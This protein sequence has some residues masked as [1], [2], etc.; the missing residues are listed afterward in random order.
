MGVASYSGASS[1]I[2]PGVVT[3]ATRP[4]S[5]FVGQ[6]I[7][8]TTVSQVLV[9]NGTAWAVQSP[10]LAPIIPTSVAV[11]SGTGSVGATGLITFSGV[12]SVS[13]NGCFTSAY[14][15]YRVVARYTNASTLSALYC[16]LRASGTNATNNYD[17]TGFR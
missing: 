12:S 3:T 13:I 9:Y 5:P 14:T 1:V 17:T 15:N 11:G 8:D 16:R 4:S 6:M 10:G 7:Y 2:K